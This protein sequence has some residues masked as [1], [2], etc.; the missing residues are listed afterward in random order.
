LDRIAQVAFQ[1]RQPLSTYL[2]L[3]TVGITLRVM[4]W[5]IKQPWRFKQS[6]KP[7]HAERDAYGK[8]VHSFASPA[9][10]LNMIQ[11]E[12]RLAALSAI[13][14]FLSTK[15]GL[16]TNVE[17]RQ[18]SEW[19][20]LEMEYLGAFEE[21]ESLDLFQ[22]SIT[23]K[24][25]THVSGMKNLKRLILDETHIR[26]L[27][28]LKD[29]TSLVHLQASFLEDENFN[30]SLDDTG[31][32]E[33]ETLSNLEYLSLWG[34]RVTDITLLRLA[35]LRRLRVLYFL[36]DLSAESITDK[37]MAVFRDLTNLEELHLEGAEVTNEGLRYLA[38]ASRL[39]VLSLDCRRITDAGLVHL[40]ELKNLESLQ[41]GGTQVTLHAAEEF[42]KTLP[43]VVISV[44]NTIVKRPPSRISF[45]RRDIDPQSSIAVP[46]HWRINQ[47]H[48]QDSD[49]ERF[50]GGVSEDGYERMNSYASE[51]AP[52]TVTLFRRPS[53][54]GKTVLE[55]VEEHL[56]ESEGLDAWSSPTDIRP[57]AQ[58]D[59]LASRYRT[60]MGWSIVWIWV[61]EG[62]CYGLTAQAP[63]E[64]FD[65]LEPYFLRIAHS[66]WFNKDGM[67][68]EVEPWP[69][70]SERS[71]LNT[72][73]TSPA[74]EQGYWQAIRAEPDADEPRLRFAEWLKL[75]GDTR[76]EFIEASIALANAVTADQRS[77][78]QQRVDE[79]FSRYGKEWLLPLHRLGL[80]QP[81]VSR[82]LVEGGAIIASAFLEHVSQLFAA[83]PMLRQLKLKGSLDVIDQL[84]N[85]QDLSRL[86][87]LDLDQNGLGSA[88]IKTLLAS[89]HLAGLQSLNLAFNDIG[90]PGAG[91]LASARHISRLNWL[92]LWSNYIGNEGIAALADAPH[93][94]NLS[95]LG[96]LFN[97]IGDPGA[98]ALAQST[99]LIHLTCLGLQSNCISD[100][101]AEAL[102]FSPILETV[103]DLRFSDNM[104]GDIGLAALAESPHLRQLRSLYIG[105]QNAYGDKGVCVL[106]ESIFFPELTTLS[107]WSDQLQGTGLYAL[108]HSQHFPYLVN[109][110]IGS[111]QVD[112][113]D[114]E[115]VANSPLLGQLASLRFSSTNL[116]AR[117]IRRLVFSPGVRSLKSLT[118][119]C[120]KMDDEALQ[121]LIDSPNLDG[122][123]ELRI[124]WREASPKIRKAFRAKF[125]TRLK[126]S[127]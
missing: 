95:Y 112:D 73:L 22:T 78:K 9:G 118:L 56:D 94:A 47:W 28:P 16:I 4:Q 106:A 103:T 39:V 61:R 93:L 81:Q 27:A 10:W 89:P 50:W 85:C 113:S 99:T 122:L 63:L 120:E 127:F 97:K 76:G 23:T 109:L 48:F 126:G 7:H 70:R 102:A 58:T 91:A 57:L 32:E 75:R 119:G 34:N 87:H 46:E 117:G 51:A 53:E 83:A 33:L 17:L 19:T 96:L 60:H 54:P 24:G 26:T 36:P 6:K 79:W 37:G 49:P 18:E 55:L 116:T 88:G 12:K 64:R 14:K 1:R 15:D 2:N 98:L 71:S 11:T 77:E 107:L 69:D 29:M 43:K 105:G 124:E 123:Q 86:R 52:G 35:S 111:R 13:G 65:K 68:P 110:D 42:L 45:Q 121:A 125:D 101:G 5:E 72:N 114:V 90:V 8:L 20:D 41:I 44:G 74:D 31:T 92:E 82:G 38:G 67:P 104:I 84:G 21:I 40:S 59:T 30:C 66:F 25:L 3:F 62:I 108:F 115:N 100:A 80:E